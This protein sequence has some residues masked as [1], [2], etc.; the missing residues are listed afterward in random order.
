MIDIE[1]LKEELRNLP[2][3][4]IVLLETS[5]DRS[6]EISLASVSVMTNKNDNGII[7]SASRPYLNLVNMYQNNDIDTGKIFVLDCIS[8]S[9]NAEVEAENV[10]YVDNVSALTNISLALND[11]IQT[12]D[13]KKF[14]FIDSISTMLIHNKPYV[15]ARFMHSILT[16]MR[17]NGI[18]GILIF[19]ENKSNREV[20]AEIA[21]LC[22]KVIKIE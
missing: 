17:L 2:E 8:K 1:K 10:R 16:K 21:Q 20:R 11:C 7:V 9:Q 4:M 3:G 13:G 19:L 22:D 12:I 5:A 15:F 18:G 14:I 6:F